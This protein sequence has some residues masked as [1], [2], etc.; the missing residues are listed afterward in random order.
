MRSLDSW[1]AEYSE[2]HQNRTNQLLHKI[3]VPAIFF[4]ILGMLWVLPIQS[5]NVAI[6]VSLLILPFY[7]RL[8]VKALAI[9]LPQ[10]L[11]SFAIL[12][13]ISQ[14]TSNSTIFTLSLAIFVV[15]WIGQFVGH[16][17][18]GKK[19]SFFKDLQFL[20]I[21]PLWIFKNK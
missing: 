7:I 16:K 2:S 10:L 4:S 3:C 12:Y 20:L 17:L 6:L 8:G 19:P 21:G 13:N 15:A 1:L 11:I 5:I 14:F 18:E 9:I